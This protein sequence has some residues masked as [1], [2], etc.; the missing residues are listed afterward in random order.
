MYVIM[1]T[2][3]T[4][5]YHRNGFGATSRALGHMMHSYRFLVLMKQR[6]LGQSSKEYNVISRKKSTT[7]RVLKFH[8]SKLGVI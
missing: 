1:K 5:G 3:S 8:R 2:F 7:H 6:V 4:P